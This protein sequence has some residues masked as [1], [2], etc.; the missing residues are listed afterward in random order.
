[1]FCK[2]CGK[3]ISDDS[4]FCSYCGSR[5]EAPNKLET[6]EKLDDDVHGFEDHERREISRTTSQV[7]ENGAKPINLK[8]TA[9]FNWDLDGFPS[10]DQRKEK[11]VSINWQDVLMTGDRDEHSTKINR[12]VEGVELIVSFLT[13]MMM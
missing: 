6:I 11:K 4:K 7:A 3:S 1:M 12:D 9:N 10:D 5:V 8:R 13:P 2:E